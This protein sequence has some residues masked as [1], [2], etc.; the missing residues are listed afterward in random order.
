M[1]V[2]TVIVAMA[3]ALAEN[4]GIGYQ[5][6][7]PWHIPADSEYLEIVTSKAYSSSTESNNDDYTNI[8][9]MGRL[10]WESIP[11]QKIPT[12]RRFN[13]VMSRDL[14][15]NVCV[16]YERES[17]VQKNN[18]NNANDNLGTSDNIF[19]MPALQTR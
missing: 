15:Y 4:W 18:T 8:V 12:K 17:L 11:M 2:E 16:W 9:I 3:A 7:L 10:S 5:Q 1:T 14:S 13:I 6:N 19:P